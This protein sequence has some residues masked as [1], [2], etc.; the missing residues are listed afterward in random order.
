[1]EHCEHV[2]ATDQVRETG[3]KLASAQIRKS[4]LYEQVKTSEEVSQWS[5]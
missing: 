4:E 5:K 1:L 2:L 3:N